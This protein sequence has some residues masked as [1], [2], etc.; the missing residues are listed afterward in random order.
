MST[1][2]QDKAARGLLGWS[3]LLLDKPAKPAPDSRFV[4]LWDVKHGQCRY[5]LG[6]PLDINAFR[7]CAAPTIGG[8]S[9][10]R[11]HMTLVYSHGERPRAA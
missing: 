11:H 2:A 6:D 4:A 1:S 9:W 8:S 5:G 10:C 7:F 3:Q